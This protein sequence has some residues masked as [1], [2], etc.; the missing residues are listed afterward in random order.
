[1]R[2]EL[3]LLADIG[4][5]GF[6]NAG[7]STLLSAI[8][9][10]RPKIADYPFTTLTPH[11]GVVAFDEERSIVMADIPG[12]IQGAHAGKGLGDQFLRHVERTR[13]LLQ[14]IDISDPTMEDPVKRLEAINLELGLYDPELAKK[15]QIIV[16]TKID[17]ITDDRYRKRLQAYCRRKHMDFIAISAAA[18]TGLRELVRLLQRHLP[19][20]KDKHHRQD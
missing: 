4:L 1:L 2:I 18:R 6:P 13:L 16:A 8:S 14:L 12:L 17:A 5:I 3:K 10:A 20:G 11:L 19:A 7:K 9:S 15:P